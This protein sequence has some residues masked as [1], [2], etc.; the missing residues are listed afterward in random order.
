LAS[1]QGCDTIVFG[2]THPK[3]NETKEKIIEIGDGKIRVINVPKGVS[4]LKLN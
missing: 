2:H 4:Y 1:S 3:D